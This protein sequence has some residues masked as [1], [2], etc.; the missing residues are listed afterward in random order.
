MSEKL[1]YWHKVIGHIWKQGDSPITQ[2]EGT[3]D[4]LFP[5]GTATGK[6][7]TAVLLGL[8]LQAAENSH[9]VR[10]SLQKAGVALEMKMPPSA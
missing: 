3:E 7:A 5:R 4:K 9:Q 10:L 2:I 1:K 6:K 8:S